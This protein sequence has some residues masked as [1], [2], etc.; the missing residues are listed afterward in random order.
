ML[1]SWS[2][3]MPAVMNTCKCWGS[4]YCVVRGERLSG[5]RAPVRR[6]DEPEILFR[7]RSEG[8]LSDR[9]VVDIP[10]QL[11]ISVDDGDGSSCGGDCARSQSPSWHSYVILEL[12]PV[13]VKG[14]LIAAVIAGARSTLSGFMNSSAVYFVN[15][16]I[17]SPFHKNS[18]PG[19]CHRKLH[20]HGV[21]MAIGILVGWKV[22]TIDSI[23]G[24]HHGS[25][26]RNA[27]SEHRKMVLVAVQWRRIRD[28]IG[29]Q[30]LPGQSFTSVDSDAPPYATFAFVIIVSTLA[31]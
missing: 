17:R 4:D 1:S 2:V 11:S 5:I 24:D 3:A 15:D 6:M 28:R 31:R 12:V 25:H 21:I 19:T 29:L 13:G 10:V 23:W 9:R 30:G 7:Q 16:I 14:L 27:P 8:K 18:S 20:Y 22:R 26:H